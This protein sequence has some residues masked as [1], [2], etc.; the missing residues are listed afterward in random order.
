MLLLWYTEPLELSVSLHQ[1][2]FTEWDNI[3]Q[4]FFSLINDTVA[5]HITNMVQ[6]SV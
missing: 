6:E 5:L 1:Y 4:L 2:D 3:E